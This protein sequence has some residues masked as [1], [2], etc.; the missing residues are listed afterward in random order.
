MTNFRTIVETRLD[1]L[2]TLRH[3]LANVAAILMFDVETYNMPRIR[4]DT[5][6]LH[7]HRE[8][9]NL[10]TLN[11]VHDSSKTKDTSEIFTIDSLTKFINVLD[12]IILY[13][14]NVNRLDIER[15]LNT[16]L[17][18]FCLT[19]FQKN[20]S[21]LEFVLPKNIVIFTNFKQ[22]FS[23]YNSTS[24]D[25]AVSFLDLELVNVLLREY[26]YVTFLNFNNNATN[27][28]IIFKYEL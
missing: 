8:N 26:N 21:D 13:Y 25:P 12:N 28:T 1:T 9:L 14:A 23:F 10:K 11:T 2:K 19:K 20:N 6:N 16:N 7:S 4:E 27:N 15:S 24:Y 22:L 5:E 18:S 17:E 3:D